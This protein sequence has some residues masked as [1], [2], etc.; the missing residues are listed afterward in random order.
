MKRSAILLLTLALPA[1][2]A[3]CSP[4]PQESPTAGLYTP[5]SYTGSAQG[6][7]GEVTATVTVDADSITDVKLTG[8]KET[9]GVGGAALEELAGQVKEKG[10][11]MEGVSGATVTSDAVREAVTAA[12]DAAG[13]K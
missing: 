2:L 1:L 10:T 13:T 5:G 4:K 3:A 6:Y 8:E 12:L 11:D 7:G 9:P